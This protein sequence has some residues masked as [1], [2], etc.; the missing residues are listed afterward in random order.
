MDLSFTDEQRAFREEI[1]DWLA[2]HVPQEPLKTFDTEEGFRQHREWEATLNGGRWGMVTWPEELGGRGCDL[3]EWLIFEEEY[4]R[5]RAPLRVNQNGIFLLGPTLM[6]YGTEEQRQR[7][8]PRMAILFPFVS[9]AI[10]PLVFANGLDPAEGPGLIF[11]TLPTAFVGMPGGAVFGA[12]FFLLLAFAAVTSII[13]IIE[14]VVAYAEDRWHMKRVT[15]CVVFG[16]LGWALGVLSV[17]SFNR[18]SDVTP[19]GMFDVFAGKTIFDLIDYFTA[20]IMMPVGAILIALFVG[21]R[22]K[23]AMHE[24]DLSFY[25]PALYKLW[26][27]TVRVIAP[28]AILGI[29]VTGLT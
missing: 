15:G 20:N 11:K 19:L 25:H 26:L 18:W 22:M 2:K 14:P 21:W 29:L 17:M 4:Y 16:L 5:A 6:E 27:W 10:F 9:L 28:V 1:R 23:P 8:L 24:G 7:F 12:L 3:V 13:A